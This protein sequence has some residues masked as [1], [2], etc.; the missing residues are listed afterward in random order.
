MSSE[1]ML[2]SCLLFGS[3]VRLGDKL[4]TRLVWL[5]WSGWLGIGLG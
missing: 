3:A 1:F 2:G 5:V 4:V